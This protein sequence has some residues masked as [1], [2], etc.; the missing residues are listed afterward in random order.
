MTCSH[1]GDHLTFRGKSMC[2]ICTFSFLTTYC[3]K[4]FTDIL[5]SKLPVVLA[6]SGG[7]HSTFLLNL[8]LHFRSRMSKPFPLTIIHLSIDSAPSDLSHLFAKDINLIALSD[9][10]DLNLHV[11]SLI[12]SHFSSSHLLF[13][14]TPLTSTAFITQS[15]VRGSPQTAVNFCAQRREVG[16]AT[17]HNPLTLFD[18]KEIEF[19]IENTD[20]FG[21]NVITPLVKS[22]NESFLIPILE[23]INSRG[24]QYL[25]NPSRVLCKIDVT[26]G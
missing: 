2:K 19:L 21:N 12:Q 8:V 15:L 11:L 5:H 18:Q 16:T 3:W 25:R 10:H 1:D 24:G 9:S 7:T 20:L 22:S 26:D 14:F 4:S 23:E 17:V 6:W 13:G